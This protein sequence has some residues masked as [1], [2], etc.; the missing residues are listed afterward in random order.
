[1]ANIL[2]INLN[3]LTIDRL[4]QKIITFLDD[5]QQHYL[6]TPNPEIIL[7]AGQDEEL[8][9]ILN[10]ADVAIADGFGLK[11]TG[12]LSGFNLPRITGADLS[13]ELL[14]IAA[15]KKIKTLILNWTGGLSKKIDI[16]SSLSQKFTDLNFQVLDIS[17]D[18]FLTPEIIEQI[19]IFSPTL[20]FT[21]L[22]FPYQEKLL[23]HNLKKL[24]SVKLALAVGGTFD[25]IS[26]K[27]R[28]APKIMRQL[29]LEWLWRLLKQPK[30]WKRIYNATIVFIGKFLYV[31]LINRWLYRPSVA[32]ILY[33]KEN[34]EKKILIVK[35][36]GSELHWQLPQG[37]TDRNS[38]AVAGRRELQE[39]L[40]IKNE[41]FVDKKTFIN[42]YHYKFDRG[43]DHQANKTGAVR[44]YRHRGY[45]GQKQSLYIAEFKGKDEEIKINFWDHT[46]WQW[47]PSEKLIENLHPIRQTGAKIFIKKFNSQ[48]L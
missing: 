22:G 38:P 48:N 40:G 26:G 41:S 3:E 25:F 39:E 16:E 29:G 6:V 20:M 44:I 2:G 9:F 12:L 17:R 31:N 24:S 1:M 45:K 18:K 43:S 11:I 21:N 32:C 27:A 14:K 8:F 36:E 33:K 46:A 34:E 15:Q 4:I 19:K 10:K 23:F 37:G 28:R 35:A 47:V 13:M 5:G 42:I 7:A 30:R